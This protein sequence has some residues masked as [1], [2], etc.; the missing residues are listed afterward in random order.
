MS[1]SYELVVVGHGAAGLSAALS[2]V[3]ACRRGARQPS[4]AVLEV[5]PEAERG[6]ATRWTT[7][8]FRARADLTLDPHFVARMQEVSGGHADADYCRR[9]EA[10][11]PGA[12]AFLSDH[13]VELI[14]YGPPVAMRVDHEVT[15][16]GGGAAIVDRLHAALAADG[17]ARFHYE[18]AAERLVV[19]D[20][21]AVCGVAVRGADGRTR[22][23]D[24][25]AVVLACGGFEGNPEMLTRYVGPGAVDLPLLA[26]GLRH[27]QGAGIRM[28]AA[29]GAA[30]AGQFDMLHTELV[31][32]RTDR[33][34]A[35]IYAHPYG[36]VVNA[37]GG[38]FWDEGQGTFEDTFELI[39][40]EVFRNQG[41][42]AFFIADQTIVSHEGV[43]LL[44]DTDRPAVEA[45][46]IG[47]LAGML[48]IEPAALERTVD[49]Y[50]AAVQP[51]AF[52]PHVCD[53]KHTTGLRP[54]KSNWAYPLVQPPFLAYPLTAA[55]CFTFGGLR[56]DAEARV[57]AANGAPIPGLYA[58]GEIV[59][60]YYHTYPVGTSVLRSLA[61]GR[62]AGERVA[63]GR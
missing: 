4:V 29:I 30:T 22:T 8:R 14:H 44:F 23:I 25:K 63:A 61:F 19:T 52:D 45:G 33:P 18:T 32:V 34:D 10:E 3:E 42:R 28:A 17:A 16:K 26:P 53:G 7:A 6:G 20:D 62:V 2:Y 57:L 40:F 35:V 13:G 41:Q 46:T 31:D 21:G 48:G 24:A 27:N 43:M 5:A 49:E 1:E 36:I 12:L 59:G 51:G 39:A 55:V 9:L 38:R 11:A 60:A 58:A 47:E 54:D 56:T 50:N 15:P 37:A